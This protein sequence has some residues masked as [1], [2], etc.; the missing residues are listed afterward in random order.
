MC[1]SKNLSIACKLLNFLGYSCLLLLLLLFSLSVM[2]DSFVTPWPVAHQAPLSMGFFQ[3]RILE[4]VAP[5]PP[6]ALPD[7][8]IKLVSPAL[9]EDSLA[10]SP[11]GNP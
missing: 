6:G 5:N 7:L 11:C 1:L 4:W 2:S 3:P 10:L 8:G 9:Q